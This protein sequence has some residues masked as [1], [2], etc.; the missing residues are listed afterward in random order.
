LFARKF[1]IFSLFDRVA[2][3]GDGGVQ[4]QELH[5]PDQSGTASS[6]WN[7]PDYHATRTSATATAMAIV[8]LPF[9]NIQHYKALFSYP[10]YMSKTTY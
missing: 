4:G 8:H 7:Y 10:R 5:A 9:E 2:L 6:P 1:S 3:L